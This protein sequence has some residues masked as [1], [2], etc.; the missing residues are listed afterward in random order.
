MKETPEQLKILLRQFADD[1][2]AEPMAE[3]IRQADH[4]LA[5]IPCPEV[6]GQSLSAIKTQV[7]NHLKV[8][9][10]QRIRVWLTSSA[11]AILLLAGTILFLKNNPPALPEHLTA[12]ASAA[13]LWSDGIIADDD[14]V[15]TLKT[16]IETI[17]GQIETVQKQNTSWFDDEN[18]LASEIQDLQTIA[19]NTDFW[20]G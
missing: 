10:H 4:L 19:A 15:G 3:D 9:S 11:A 12:S 6:S 17:A 5:S 2:S 16:Q 8:R 1:H 18:S 20:K 13:Y 7:R 14:P